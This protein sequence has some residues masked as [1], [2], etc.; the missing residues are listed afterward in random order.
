MEAC[1]DLAAEGR[2]IL[3]ARFAEA[4]VHNMLACFVD[5]D[6]ESDEAPV[7]P[8]ETDPEVRASKRAK[9]AKARR[10]RN[11]KKKQSPCKIQ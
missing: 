4:G 5:M 3:A 6:V 8:S 10:Q 1:A 2:A 9:K 11:E 7:A